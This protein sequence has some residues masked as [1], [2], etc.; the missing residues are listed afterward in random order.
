MAE[1]SVTSVQSYLKDHFP[2]ADVYG[3]V[4]DAELRLITCGGAF[5]LAPATT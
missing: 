3:P 2:T 1:F 4:P 5:D